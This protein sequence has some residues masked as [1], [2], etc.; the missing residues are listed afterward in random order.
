MVLILNFSVTISKSD[1]LHF[2]TILI[3]HNDSCMNKFIETALQS[4]VQTAIKDPDCYFTSIQIH[5]INC[6]LKDIV[7][8]VLIY[9]CTFIKTIRFIVQITK[10]L[11][12]Q[13]VL[14]SESSSMVSSH[15]LSSSVVWTAQ[16]RRKKIHANQKPKPAVEADFPPLPECDQHD[17][18]HFTAV[19]FLCSSLS[20]RKRLL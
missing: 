3:M 14:I 17:P 10:Q 20:E 11:Y 5:K 12:R 18:S 1:K 16:Y 8:K 19:C 6:N 9:M 2:K 15:G 4:C 7:D 13:Y